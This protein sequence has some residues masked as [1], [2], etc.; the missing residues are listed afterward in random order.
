VAGTARGV[1]D[2]TDPAAD[3]RLGRAGSRCHCK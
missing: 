3:R 2:T 1:G